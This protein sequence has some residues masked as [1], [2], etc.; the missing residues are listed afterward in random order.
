V[1]R[2]VLRHKNFQPFFEAV[3]LGAHLARAAH[4]TLRHCGIRHAHLLHH[5]NQSYL[6]N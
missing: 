3:F 2:R 4:V 1:N 6:L 5:R